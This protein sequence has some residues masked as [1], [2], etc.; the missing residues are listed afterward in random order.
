MAFPQWHAIPTAIIVIIS[1]ICCAPFAFLSGNTLILSLVL[2]FGVFMDFVDHL[3][4]RRIKK[5][6]RGEK[7]PIPEWT[8]WMHTWQALAGVII[9]VIIVGNV[10]PLISYVIHILID[11]GDNNYEFFPHVA[12]LPTVIHPFYPKWLTYKTPI[13]I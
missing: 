13:I 7:G 9:V 12:P 4:V 11:G 3:S 10:L 5:I 1:V 8:N 6:L 2:F